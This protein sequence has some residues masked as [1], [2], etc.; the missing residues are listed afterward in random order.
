MDEKERAA[1]F[2]HAFEHYRQEVEGLEKIDLGD[3]EDRREAWAEVQRLIN[4]M[5]ALIPVAADPL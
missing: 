3:V 5:Q 1:K 4:E 2:S